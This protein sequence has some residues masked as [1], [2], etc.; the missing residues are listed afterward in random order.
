M[1]DGKGRKKEAKL[2]KWRNNKSEEANQNGCRNDN[3][4]L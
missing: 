1:E 3:N 2:Q 4:F